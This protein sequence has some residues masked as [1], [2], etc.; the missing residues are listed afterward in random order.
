MKLQVPHDTA[1]PLVLECDTAEE[2]V[3]FMKTMTD[4]IDGFLLLSG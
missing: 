1:E 4:L 3:K 2:R